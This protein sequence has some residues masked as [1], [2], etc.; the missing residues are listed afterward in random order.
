MLPDEL[1]D[2][3]DAID[4]LHEYVEALPALNSQS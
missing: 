1:G 2:P 4:L 3:Q